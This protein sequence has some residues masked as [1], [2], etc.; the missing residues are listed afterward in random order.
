M[1]ETL[2]RA[3]LTSFGLVFVLGIVTIVALSLV[4]PA[5]DG[6]RTYSRGLILGAAW[7][8]TLISGLAIII[9]LVLM[10]ADYLSTSRNAEDV[11][12]PLA[13]LGSIG[14][15]LLGAGILTV[16]PWFTGPV[17]S[18]SE[19]PTVRVVFGSARILTIAGFA[20][21]LL[22]V[23][24]WPVV[25]CIGIPAAVISMATGRHTATQQYAM[26]ALMGA[27]AKHSIPLETAVAAFGAERGGWM[28]RRARA[29]VRQLTEGVPLPAAIE[30]VPGVLPPEA[31][32]LIR[33]GHD[34]GALPAAIDRAIES[35]NLFEPVW[36]SIVPKIG[37]VC[38]L[39]SVAIGIVLF[40]FLKIVP[41]YE[42]IFKD[43]GLRLPAIT[44]WIIGAGSFLGQWWFLFAP[45]WLLTIVLLFYSMLRYVGWIR[46]DLPGMAWLTRRRHTATL[47]DAIS[48][49]A[50]QQQPL[51]N[52]VRELAAGY[53]QRKIARRLWSAYDDMEAGG[54]VFE[55][56]YRHSLLEKSDLALLRAAMRNGNL[57]WA[58]QELADSNCRRMI[59]RTNALTQ[60]IFPPIIVIYAIAVVF[61]V[62]GLFLPMLTLIQNL[63]GGK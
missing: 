14:A 52:A 27:A 60:V 37:Y 50:R 59:Y 49:A 21:C 16:M 44:E 13:V 46:G 56:L 40:I 5:S 51:S 30:E 36:Q 19:S 12:F 10:M 23:V 8:L 38:L 4:G 24:P 47:L 25:F 7:T 34:T 15:F 53:P 54:D 57:A 9:C 61:L 63:S 43:F 26:L 31:V 32:P 45:I 48:L 6:R 20:L 28:R 18:E 33:V 3:L 1:D 58:A 62:T 22:L 11:A 41:Q 39:P 42:K 29:F 35:H 17:P 2:R 55:S